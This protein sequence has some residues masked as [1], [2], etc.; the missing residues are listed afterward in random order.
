MPTDAEREALAERLDAEAA[1]WSATCGDLFAEARD[2]ITRL[3]AERDEWEAD[4]NRRSEWHQDACEEVDRLTATLAAV[5]AERDALR[6]ALTRFDPS[7]PPCASEG[8]GRRSVV[9][10]VR[11]GIGTYFCG[12]CYLRVHRLEQGRLSARALTQEKPE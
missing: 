4:A 9:H 10:F 6:E 5:E 12:D 2:E 3:R 11:G 8:C 7:F 1:N